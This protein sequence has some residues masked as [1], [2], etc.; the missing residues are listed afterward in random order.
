MFRVE[1]QRQKIRIMEAYFFGR[2]QPPTLQHMSKAFEIKKSHP[3][4]KL[5]MGY[6]VSTE[7]GRSQQNFLFAEEVDHLIKSSLDQCGLVDI[8]CIPVHIDLKFPLSY[9]LRAFFDKR[10]T[11]DPFTVFSGSSSTLAACRSLQTEYPV[12]VYEFHDFNPYLR[13]TY[14]REGLISKSH[15]WD[16]LVTSPVLDYL[17]QSHIQD[18][19]K[20][21]SPGPK[22]PWAP[23][24]QSEL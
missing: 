8:G 1:Y 17:N 15:S 10:D 6:A 2:F 4:L 14:I 11:I 7:S 22:R 24:N 21:L 19:I 5:N 18:R 20:N 13:A 12:E 3:H 9:S 23:I 16:H